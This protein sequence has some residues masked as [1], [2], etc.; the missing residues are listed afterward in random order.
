MFGRCSTITAT[1]AS[2][3]EYDDRPRV[4]EDH[5]EDGSA[6]AVTIEATDA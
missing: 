5:D 6:T 3:A 4:A 2:D 1:A